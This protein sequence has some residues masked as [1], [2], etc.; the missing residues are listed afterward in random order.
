MKFGVFLFFVFTQLLFRNIQAQINTDDITGIWQTAGG[1][2]AAKIQIYKSGQKYYGA[3][4]W[5]K[6]PDENGV[7]RI[8][9]H[10]PDK[11]KRNDP[12]VGLVIMRDFR[13]NGKDEWENGKI[14]DPRSGNTYSSYITLKN[15]NTLKITGYIGIPL[16]GRT[17]TWTRTSL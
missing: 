3:I 12:I 13:F 9:I 15:Q 2:A 10:N 16:F 6:S 4:V 11:S 7:R 8:D 5:L 17:E 1:D 14:Y